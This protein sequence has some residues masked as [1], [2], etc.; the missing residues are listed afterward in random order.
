MSLTIDDYFGMA[1]QIAKELPNE[2][3]TYFSYIVHANGDIARELY[4]ELYPWLKA[5]CKDSI[6]FHFSKKATSVENYD[7]VLQL[8]NILWKI[9]F[10]NADRDSMVNL[11]SYR[12]KR[13][14]RKAYYRRVNKKEYSLRNDPSPKGILFKSADDYLTNQ[15]LMMQ[16]GA[17]IYS[18]KSDFIYDFYTKIE[19]WGRDK[20][21]SLVS[22]PLF[23]Y[24]SNGKQLDDLE[25]DLGFIFFNAVNYTYHGKCTNDG[26]ITSI[27]KAVHDSDVFAVSASPKKANVDVEFSKSMVRVTERRDIEG[28][29]G[30]LLS[31]THI[32]KESEGSFK[33]DIA[34]NALAQRDALSQ[35]QERGLLNVQ[36]SG[37]GSLDREIFTLAYN[38]LPLNDTKG[39][40]TT[41]LSALA[42][43]L[44]KRQCRATYEDLV[45]HIQKISDYKL[46]YTIYPDA[47]STESIAGGTMRLFSNVAYSY[48]DLSV[49][50]NRSFQFD[51][52]SGEDSDRNAAYMQDMLQRDDLSDVEVSLELGRSMLDLRNKVNINILTS[53]YEKIVP[54]EYKTVLMI[55][56]ELRLDSKELTAHPTMK[57]FVKRLK[58]E[59][60]RPAR[61]KAQLE[62]SFDYILHQGIVLKSYKIGQYD[63]E[64]TFLPFSEL[65]KKVIP[66]SPGETASLEDIFPFTPNPAG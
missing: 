27:P 14:Q 40:Y 43:R 19:E 23:S 20:D 53:Y 60:S 34:T 52:R 17:K 44:H 56:Q 29:D 31:T 47:D 51:L 9:N 66:T 59:N 10:E 61:V 26:L 49:D 64:L 5:E 35:L 21:T 42:K 65:E 1:D 55:L 18:S 8:R 45:D 41:S 57:F 33:K 2:I 6:N 38:S 37:L 24:V 13:R 36:D 22:F 4:A 54:S 39:V 25:L 11:L 46:D 28:P 62:E 15:A 48:G 50:G 58:M 7:S 30:S 16:T 12:E 63:V 3:Q 32:Y